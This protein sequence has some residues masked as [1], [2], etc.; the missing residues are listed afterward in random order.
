MRLAGLLGQEV[1][2]TRCRWTSEACIV[3]K[4]APGRRLRKIA[5]EGVL[6]AEEAE[7]VC[8]LHLTL[9]ENQ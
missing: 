8:L 4:V 9:V 6:L 1:P 2:K 3:C 7:C 5:E